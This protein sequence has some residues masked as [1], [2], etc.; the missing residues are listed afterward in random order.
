MYVRLK[1]FLIERKIKN[2]EVALQL[3]MSAG[4]FSKKINNKKNADFNLNQVRRICELYGLDP[5][6]YFFSNKSCLND[7][8]SK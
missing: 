6:I 5:N 2:K 8:E 3:G 1:Q 4:N 7:N